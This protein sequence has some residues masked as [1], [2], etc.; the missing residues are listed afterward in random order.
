MAS[1]M[2]VKDFLLKFCSVGSSFLR[3]ED[4]SNLLKFLN[5]IA[6]IAT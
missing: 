1:F 3:K 5:N 4:V 6:K 2:E